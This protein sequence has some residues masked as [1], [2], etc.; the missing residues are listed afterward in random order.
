[1]T[2]ADAPHAYAAIRR[3]SELAEHAS[4]KERAYIEA[5]AVRYVV[6]FNPLDHARQDRAYADAMGRVAQRYPD[7]PDAATL[8]AEALFLLVA[9]EAHA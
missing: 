6:R 5:M 8:D 2:A 1:M 9:Y 7:D 3:A 4:P